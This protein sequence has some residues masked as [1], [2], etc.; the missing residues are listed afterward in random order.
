VYVSISKKKILHKVTFSFMA[1]LVLPHERRKI[2][3]AL[4]TVCVCTVYIHIDRKRM[5]FLNRKTTTNE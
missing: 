1:L 4:C 2:L 5:D 3:W